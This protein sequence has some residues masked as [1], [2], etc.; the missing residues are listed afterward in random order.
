MPPW[1]EPSPLA[2]EMTWRGRF[3]PMHTCDNGDHEHSDKHAGPAAVRFK[4]C[5]ICGKGFTILG[6]GEQGG[7]R[8]QARVQD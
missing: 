3:G 1:P 5:A 2:N 6:L 4:K 8:V 7:S